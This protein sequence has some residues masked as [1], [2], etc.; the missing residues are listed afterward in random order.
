MAEIIVKEGGVLDRFLASTTKVQVF[1]GGFANGKT[2]GAVAKALQIGLDWYPGA[3][4]LMARETYPKLNDTLRAEFIK[5][6]PKEKIASFPMSTNSSNV[7]TLKNGTR[8]NFRYIQQQGTKE[9]ATTSNLLSATYDLVV[10]DQIEDPGITH[11]DWLDLQGRLRGNTVYRGLDPRM[12]RTG[13]RW[14][15][16]TLNPTRNWV[17]KELIEPLYQWTGNGKKGERDYYPGGV[18]SDKLFCVRDDN[19]EPVLRNGEPILLLELFEASTYENKHNLAGDFIQTL[20]SSYRGQMRQRFLLG[21]WGAYEGLVY[22]QWDKQ[23]HMVA[24]DE[25]MA[26]LREHDDYEIQ[27]LEGYDFGLAAPSCWLLAFIDRNGFV[28]VVD[29]FYGAEM[30]IEVQARKIQ[31]KRYL[32]G[33]PSDTYVYADPDV[34]RRKMAKGGATRISDMFFM[35]HDVRM[36]RA[37]NDMK[38]GILKVQT[39]LE[40]SRLHINPFTQDNGSPCIFINEDLDFIDTE[41]SSYMWKK[42]SQG[43]ASDDVTRDVNDHSLDTIKYL[44]TT[45][46]LASILKPSRIKRRPAYLSWHEAPDAEENRSRRHG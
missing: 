3:N 42:D 10:V 33:A 19:Y 39:Y 37:E 9:E 44:L 4:I 7:C 34:F 46:P 15:V 45:L 31:E 11:K 29:G 18:I 43:K 35:D 26:Y 30:P 28:I 22:P 8:Y 1:A 17:W 2:T 13:P 16:L 23:V 14:M 27:W 40:V 20:E 5:W 12:P 21:K 32:W 41:M 36:Q 24:K 38:N 25:V 6:C